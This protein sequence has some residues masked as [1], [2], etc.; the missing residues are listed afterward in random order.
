MNH[1]TEPGAREGFLLQVTRIMVRVNEL[2]MKLS[3]IALLA[4]A[5]I[6]TLSVVTR[7]LLKVSTDWQDETSVF[8]IV[9]AIFMCGAY[10][11]S[12]R[13]HVGI[14]ALA[15]VLP[16]RVN[17]IRRIFIDL[18]SFAFCAFFSWKSWAMLHEAWAGGHTTASTFAP[19]LWIPYGLLALGMSNLS[20]QILLQLPTHFQPDRST[21]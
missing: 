19:P 10:V 4:S 17:W 7:Y 2:I 5:L 14:E 13:G 15:S 20:L 8:L 11:Q 1:G 12:Y 18:F 16:P 3:M 9:G 6:L 21:P